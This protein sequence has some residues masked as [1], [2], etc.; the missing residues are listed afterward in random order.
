MLHVS[1]KGVTPQEAMKKAIAEYGEDIELVTTKQISPSTDSKAA[2]YEVIVAIDNVAVQKAKAQSKKLQAYNTNT[3]AS[4]SIEESD[5][6]GV[7]SI[8]NKAYDSLSMQSNIQKPQISSSNSDEIR[9]LLK[10]VKQIKEQVDII[11]DITWESLS[12]NRNNLPIPPEFA[13][14]YKA[15]KESG[16]KPEHLD[17]I[18]RATIENMPSSMKSNPTAVKRYFY[19]LL[20]NMLPCRKQSIDSKQRI[21]MLVGPTG[22]GKTTTLAKLAARFAHA[23]DRRFKTGVITLDT[24]RIGAVEQLAQYTRMMRIEML[25]AIE[26]ED[27]K[28]AIKSLSYCDVILVDTTG[29]SQHDKDKLLRLDKFLKHSDAQIDVSLVLSAGQK[30]EDLLDT[31]NSFSFLDIDTLIITKFDETRIFGNVFSLIYETKTPVS[32]FCVGQDVPDDIMEAKS[33][34]LARCVLDGF[35]AEQ[36]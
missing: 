18:M 6:G 28:S 19:S 12:A 21:M 35:N 23:G 20:R 22:V 30:V 17:A 27:F 26:I 4:F 9:D 31:Y 3:R 7:E 2:E 33:D 16:M 25:D 10:Q 36:E 14:I 1:F 24:Y 11:S 8:I 5:D 15:S 32:Y 13:S 29:S 34:F